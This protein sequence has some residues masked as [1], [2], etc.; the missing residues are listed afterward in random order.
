MPGAGDDKSVAQETC[1]PLL[2]TSL[3]R[4]EFVKSNRPRTKQAIN[5]LFRARTAA[6]ASGDWG[7]LDESVGPTKQ[8]LVINY[9]AAGGVVANWK[10]ANYGKN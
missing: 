9:L 1:G 2:R 3:L 4:A 10:L 8:G 5:H 7:R 6:A